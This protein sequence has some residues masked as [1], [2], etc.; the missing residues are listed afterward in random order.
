[1]I[2]VPGF[3][4]RTP[5]KMGLASFVYGL[6]LLVVVIAIIAIIDPSE[7]TL[8]TKE[9]AE[10]IQ[11]SIINAEKSLSNWNISDAENSI[12][13]IKSLSPENE[14]LKELEGN[15]EH[16][17]QIVAEIGPA[18][19]NSGWDAS[20][21]EVKNFLDANLKDPKSVQ[22]AEWSKVNL[23]TYQNQKCWWVRCKYRAKN[24]FGGYVVNNQLFYISNGKVIGYKDYSN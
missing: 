6:A 14:K 7:K 1:M 21:I 2:P 10:K 8:T 16:A 12:N 20:V 17:K 18:P 19:V 24:S 4:S 23:G 9:K 15:L 3:R 13:T 11:T 22:Y 5:W